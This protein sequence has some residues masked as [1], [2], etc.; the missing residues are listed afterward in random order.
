MTRPTMTV[1]GKTYEMPNPKAGM[2]RKL[3]TFDKEQK[4]IF[5][6]DF[7][8]RHCGFLAEIYG[9]GLTAEK[10]IEELPLEE[11]MKSYREVSNYL[12]KMLTAKLGEAEK[13]VEAGDKTEQ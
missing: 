12:L 9:G 11:V 10:L 2:W 1:A 13:N 3:M 4:N 8:E 7:I 6:E 5:D